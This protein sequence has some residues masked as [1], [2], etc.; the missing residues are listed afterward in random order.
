MRIIILNLLV[1][2]VLANCSRPTKINN[3]YMDYFVILNDIISSEIREAGN[4]SKQI[5]DTLFVIKTD[6]GFKGESLKK[7]VTEVY[8]RSKEKELDFKLVLSI[9]IAESSFNP[10]ASSGSSFGLFQVNYGVHKERVVSKQSLYNPSINIDIGTDIIKELVREYRG[11]QYP[12]AFLKKNYVR[13]AS[14]P[15]WKHKIKISEEEYITFRYFGIA[16]HINTNYKYT[17][18]ILTIYASI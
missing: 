7:Y 12:V 5:N 14:L 9:M 11:L 13:R 8:D 18:R 6:L 2:V 3:L 15:S 10:R 17:N 4:R 16:R 1:L